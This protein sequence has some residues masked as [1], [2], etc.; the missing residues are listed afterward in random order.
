M[1]AFEFLIVSK[2]LTLIKGLLV[3]FLLSKPEKC[4]LSKTRS[5]LRC[6]YIILYE[7]C[8]SEEILVVS[9]GQVILFPTKLFPRRCTNILVY[10]LTVE[11]LG[12]RRTSPEEEDV[13]FST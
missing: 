9:Y 8:K 11:E 5:L 6:F 10:T 4:S 12:P 1:S 7:N 2:L 3:S 13:K